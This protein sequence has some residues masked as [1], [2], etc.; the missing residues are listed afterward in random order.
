[1]WTPIAVAAGA[2]SNTHDTPEQ[3]AESLTDYYK[4][5][6][7]TLINLG[8]LPSGGCVD[9]KRL[10]VRHRLRSSCNSVSTSKSATAR[11]ISY[12]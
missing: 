10:V 11:K 5:E 3:V 12:S 6:V 8:I 9:A 4:A 2:F 1:M 7:T